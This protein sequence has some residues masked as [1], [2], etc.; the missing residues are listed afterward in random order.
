MPRK[1]N[2]AKLLK[3]KAEQGKLESVLAYC[4]N[5]L[6]E[7][8]EFVKSMGPY[9]VYTQKGDFERNIEMHK[10]ADVVIIGDHLDSFLPEDKMPNLSYVPCHAAGYDFVPNHVFERGIVV[11][12]LPTHP[13]HAVSDYVLACLERFG[14]IATSLEDSYADKRNL[15]CNFR[16]F[17]GRKEKTKFGGLEGEE[18]A[19]KP[20]IIR[21][22]L[23]TPKVGIIGLGRIGID[24]AKKL[25]EF[26]CSVNY[27][28]RTR[29]PDLEEKMGVKY[30]GSAAEIAKQS[31][32]LV[33]SC[34]YDESSKGLIGMR[35]VRALEKGKHNPT[36]INVSRYGVIKENAYNH[37]FSPESRIKLADDVL[38][39]S[40]AKPIPGVN[41]K[42]LGDVFEAGILD[43]GSEY[44]KR[45]VLTPHNAFNTSATNQRKL[46]EFK[47][48]FNSVLDGKPINRV[49]RNV[50]GG[51]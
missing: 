3:K 16:L 10:N 11:T 34:G 23:I 33:I 9:M 17:L 46:D 12:N 4:H 18:T 38:Y 27:F 6:P 37:L 51:K 29:K 13:T 20:N 43:R 49:Y 30:C 14:F 50:G 42:V 45:I 22:E 44:R 25:S 7:A 32:I 31:D 1:K 39:D 36:L 19:S 26:G 5:I 28:S 24:T 8:V 40:I 41:Y 2:T 47:E 15:E 21:N 35:E 48:T